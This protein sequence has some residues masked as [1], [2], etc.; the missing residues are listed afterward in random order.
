MTIL[1]PAA[2][3]IADLAA[4][5]VPQ[6]TILRY[7]DTPPDRLGDVTFYCLPYMDAARATKLM[8][9]MPRLEVVQSLSSGVDDV[10][11]AVPPQAVLCNGRG[12]GHEEGTAELA[13]LL[14]LASLRQLPD[15]VRHQEQRSWRHVR[16]ESLDGKRILL[17]GYG[18][19]GAAA[20]ERLRPFGAQFSRISRTAKDGVAPLSQLGELAAA[21]DIMVV[22]IALTPQTR[23]LVDAGVLAALPDRALVVN[24][25]RGPVIDA[26]A[27]TR[28]LETGR[29]RAALDV[30]DPE[31][32]PPDRPEWELPNVLITPHV[33]GDTT[34]FAGRSARFVADQVARH[35]AG[36][37]LRNIVRPAIRLRLPARSPGPGL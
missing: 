6:A 19:I 25:A 1:L 14:I 34:A 35:L 5:R 21:A 3:G 15:F 26:P 10:L 20:E 12:L 33:G 28:E 7:E 16:A 4:E 24:V 2:D 27:L 29:L 11:D 13:A 18:A 32:L 36:Q 37:P 8:A 30:T 31:P 9:S 17:V 23:G 22:C